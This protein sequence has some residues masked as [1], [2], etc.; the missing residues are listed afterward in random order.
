MSR[1]TLITAAWFLPQAAG[2]GDWTVLHREA[3]KKEPVLFCVHFFNAWQKLV[4]FF[5]N[6][7]NRYKESISY[8]NMYLMLAC[9][10]NYV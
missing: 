6:R 7:K 4:N 2:V 10:K 8:Y 1:L 9:V 3:E 5:A